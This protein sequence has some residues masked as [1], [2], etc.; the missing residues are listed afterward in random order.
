[1]AFG[2]AGYPVQ[3]YSPSWGGW[4]PA[5]FGG[6]MPSPRALDQIQLSPQ[7]L[8]GHPWI[9]E[10]PGWSY[11]GPGSAPAW[12]GNGWSDPFY[13]TPSPHDP[14]YLRD[15]EQFL[16]RARRANGAQGPRTVDGQQQGQQGTLRVRASTRLDGVR[17]TE[18]IV[19]E[20]G[21]WRNRTRG[22]AYGGN[23]AEATMSRGRVGRSYQ[24]TI[25]WEDGTRTVRDVPL[26]QPDQ[27]LWIS[28]TY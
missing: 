13:G 17:P 21:N 16:D 4:R 1:M 26:S 2:I 5:S 15:V 10:L 25:L 23:D 12:R 11:G 3:T 27:S 24:V 20:K 22:Y 18:V 9:G 19:H 7:A 8:Y 28:T 14:G 6:S